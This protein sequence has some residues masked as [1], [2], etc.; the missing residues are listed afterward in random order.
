MWKLNGTRSPERLPGPPRPPRGGCAAWS[1]ML[2]TPTFM[3]LGWEA[4]LGIKA[5]FF[6]SWQV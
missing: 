2:A 5:Q 1:G 3:S 6:K 4:A